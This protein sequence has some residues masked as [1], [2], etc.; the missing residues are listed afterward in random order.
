MHRGILPE[1]G[2][3]LEGHPGS[4]STDRRCPGEGE[5]HEVSSVVVG[6]LEVTSRRFQGKPSCLAWP[7]DT[8]DSG[9][10]LP[11]ALRK[12]RLVRASASACIES[13]QGLD[14]ELALERESGLDGHPPPC[15]E[16]GGQPELSIASVAGRWQNWPRW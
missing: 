13:S 16:K 10:V 8:L 15:T 4:G 6:W 11:S 7:L 3:F 5:R 12:G 2:H 9:G 1:A 14:G